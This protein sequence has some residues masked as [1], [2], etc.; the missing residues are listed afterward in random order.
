[1]EI[2][3]VTAVDAELVEAELPVL[4][5]DG[6]ALAGSAAIALHGDRLD[7]YNP[8]SLF[9]FGPHAATPRSR[10]TMGTL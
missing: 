8:G 1:M 5:E 2:L 6:G 7:G 3:D 10:V 9:G 4:L